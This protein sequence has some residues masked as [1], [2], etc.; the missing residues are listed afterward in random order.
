V[1]GDHH[2]VSGAAQ[3]DADHGGT[4][5]LGGKWG[6]C[7]QTA[8]ASLAES[9]MNADCD[10]STGGWKGTGGSLSFQESPQ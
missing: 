1:L 5:G 4:G 6:G 2:L 10:G 8:V 7:E 9:L 3:A